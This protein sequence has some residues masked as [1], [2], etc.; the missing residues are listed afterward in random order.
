M[1]PAV[2]QIDSTLIKAIAR[3]PV[4]QAPGKLR[5]WTIEELAA[6]EKINASYI[7]P[8]SPTDSFA[9]DLWKARPKGHIRNLDAALRQRLATQTVTP[10]IFFRGRPS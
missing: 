9:P 2:A 6:A 8:H 1:L 7:K 10:G 5:I 4:A 3:L